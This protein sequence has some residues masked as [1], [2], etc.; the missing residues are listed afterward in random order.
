MWGCF[1][2]STE[3]SRQLVDTLCAT[4]KK[5]LSDCYLRKGFL[6]KNGFIKTA[7]KL[8]MALNLRYIIIAQIGI[9]RWLSC[10]GRE[11]SAL[12][13]LWPFI[14]SRGGKINRAGDLGLAIWAGA[15][16]DKPCCG[17]FVKR[18]VKTWPGLRRACNA[19]ELAWVVQGLA[20]YSKFGVEESGHLEVLEDAH[21][22]LTALHC[23]SSGLFARH[24]R[25]GATEVLGRA[26]ACFADQVY[27]ITALAAFGEYYHDPVSIHTALSAAE[28]IC[29]LQGRNG[30]WWWHYDPERAKVVEEYPIFSVHQDAMAPMALLAV[31]KV[32]GTDHSFYIERGLAWLDEFNELKKKMI[33]P[34]EGIVWRDIHRREIRKSYRLVRGL[35]AAG[36]FPVAHQLAGRNLFGYVLNRQ[37][38]PYH[39]GWILYAWAGN[40]PESGDAAIAGGAKKTFNRPLR[41]Y[42]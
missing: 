41:E 13:D 14:W 34:A 36:N 22:R 38:R 5:G 20:A 31:D 27:P 28:A 12:P 33:R 23:H 19:V 10:Y 6:G 1:A 17:V 30:Q 26:V 25:G 8:S 21:R 2:D 15:E 29:R 16:S 11:R 9:R 39:L 40:L 4:A 7:G 3:Q 37:C 42:N 32:A 18:L 24:R 35:L